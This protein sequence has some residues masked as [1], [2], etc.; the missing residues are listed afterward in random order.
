MRIGACLL[1][2]LAFFT[3]NASALEQIAGKVTMLEASY[4]PAVV[5][6]RMDSGSASCPAGNWLKWQNNDP[7]NNKVV[8]STLMAA[9]IAEK[10]IRFY[11][12]DGDTRCIGKHIHLIK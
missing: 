11:I 9:L 3:T 10:S 4:L 8:Y 5:T 6:F 1:I 12:D 7:E 2:A